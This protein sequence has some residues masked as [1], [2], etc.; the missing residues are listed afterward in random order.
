MLFEGEIM[1]NTELLKKYIDKFVVYNAVKY[2]VDVF[3]TLEGSSLRE[4]E[5][6]GYK[7]DIFKSARKKLNG[8][9][10]Y[11]DIILKLLPGGNLTDFHTETSGIHKGIQ[12]YGKEDVDVV[13]KSFY[14]GDN[15]AD[16]FEE[17]KMVCC[18]RYDQIG[19]IYFT[20]DCEKYLPIR[21][22]SFDDRFKFLGIKSELSGNCSWEKYSFFISTIKEIQAELKNINKEITLLDAHSFVWELDKYD[23]VE[24]SK[25]QLVHHKH[26]DF[27]YGVVRDE[28]D[29]FLYV[30]FSNNRIT[31]L[32]KEYV[33][34]SLSY[35]HSDLNKIMDNEWM[36]I[37]NP[38]MYDIHGAFAT[39]PYVQWRQKTNV[40]EN[41]TVYIYV[42]API[43]ALLYKCQAVSVD[44]T[45]LL[46]DDSMFFLD[47]SFVADNNRLMTL[48][49]KHKYD[50]GGIP[51]DELKEHGLNNVQ[52]PHR[53]TP[54]LRKYISEKSSSK[55]E[56][57][58]Y[59]YGIHISTEKWEEILTNDS[60]TAKK[61][62]DILKAF[63]IHN[64]HAAT[65]FQ[66]AK[67][68]D[69]HPNYYVNAVVSLGKR[70]LRYLDKEALEI[71]HGRKI[72]W[73]IFFVGKYLDDGHFEW[74]LR[75]ELA[76]AIENILPEEE[77]E[78][79]YETLSDEELRIRAENSGSEV[80]RISE[81]VTKTF[82]R[83][84]DVANHAKRRA[85]G[86]CELCGK[87]APF[88]TKSGVP[89]LEA[90]HIQP[91]AEGGPDTIY[92]VAAL[93]PNCHRKMHS[94]N[95]QDDINRLI[96]KIK[97]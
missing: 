60:V 66:L 71:E 4:K 6:E 65:C 48:Y 25:G 23:K 51:Y 9:L 10:S 17:I 76:S 82:Y 49:P 3:E 78:P 73:P 26:K 80:V 79:F 67:E 92:N 38:N 89:Y 50:N 34:E 24:G 69:A 37:C 41:D 2:N 53:I 47:E 63:Y 20:K 12:E 19:F 70:V 39:F 27:G 91:L 29:E 44:K 5:A 58:K 77:T 31:Q 87:E 13:L 68:N 93:C 11:T 62:I 88:K 72:Y 90:H 81:H 14:E 33:K 42:G 94:L 30:E 52:G 59:D 8:A 57:E 40:K 85:N 56:L 46:I 95:D 36:Y 28:D 97:N 16:S 96:N 18:N 7:Y 32:K 22:K 64:N 15:D 84:K 43:K 55:V 83:S 45:E 74:R 21:S 75:E 61:D 86:Y 1:I 35:V 54:E